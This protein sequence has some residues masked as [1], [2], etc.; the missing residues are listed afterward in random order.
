MDLSLLIPARNEKFLARTIEDLLKNIRGD[1]EI[2]AV[3]DGQWSDPPIADNPRVHLIYYPESIGQRAACNR[4]AAMST[5]KYVMKV[6]AHCAFDEGFDVKLLAD[7]QDNWTMVPV[8]RNLHIF[9][10]LCADCGKR[11]YQ[12][13]TPSVCPDCGGK[14]AM[15]IV[16]IAKSNPQSRSYCFDREPHFQYFNDYCKR[17]EYKAARD[18]EHLTDTM[19]LQGSCFL[20]TRERY[21]A[22]NVCDESWGSWGSQGIEVAVKTWLS[23]GRVVVNHNTWYAHCFRTQGGDFGFPYPLSAK[24]TEYAKSRARDMLFKDGFPGQVRPL[25]WLI[26][27]FK[28]IPGWDNTGNENPVSKGII[29]YTDNRIDE[30]IAESCR[31]QI[32]KANLP[33]NSA[34]LQPLEFGENVVINEPRGYKAMFRQILAALQM[35]RAEA[36]FFCEHDVLYHPSHFNFIPP[37]KDVFFYN[38]NTWKVDAETGQALFYYTKQTSGLCCYRELAIEHYAKRLERLE[39]EGKHDYRI[40]FEP[41]CHS[42]PRGIDNYPAERWMSDA[43]NVDIRHNKNL[44]PSRWSQ[45]Q[46]RNRRNCQGWQMADEVPGWGI[47]KGRFCDF[48]AEATNE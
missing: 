17:A 19:S 29:Y 36:V 28:P 37:K 23:G 9:D 14:M 5:A 34:S 11:I 45:D 24:Q 26:D 6:D 12:G 21:F 8:M 33:I 7:M 44:T 16:W 25:S 41:G 18:S 47:T 20:M 32:A 30:P 43:P 42:F 27:K 39:R 48:L 10:W 38:E 13:P 22:L 35:S 40:G 46:F 15:D 1:T 31:R 2:I 4:A 3:L